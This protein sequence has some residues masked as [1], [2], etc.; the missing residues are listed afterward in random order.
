MNWKN[1]GLV[2]FVASHSFN[3]SPVHLMIAIR[4]RFHFDLASIWL[5]LKMNMFIFCNTF[6]QEQ[7]Q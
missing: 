6:Q 3:V 5:R 7:K 2:E 4:L 1:V